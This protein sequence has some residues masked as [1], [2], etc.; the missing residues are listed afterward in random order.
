ML[1]SHAS[2]P[3][4]LAAHPA[5]QPR[6]QLGRTGGD[7]SAGSQPREDARSRRAAGGACQQT[8]SSFAA[9]RKLRSREEVAGPGELALPHLGARLFA[10]SLGHDLGVTAASLRSGLDRRAARVA[11]LGAPRPSPPHPATSRSGSPSHPSSALAN[12]F[13]VLWSGSGHGGWSVGRESRC[14]C[15]A[16]SARL[17]ATAAAVAPA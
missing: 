17:R 15:R 9:G 4:R 5:R 10:F 1:C 11:G 12:V 6:Q 2:Q 7:C 3:C 13:G 16:S 8:P 14:A